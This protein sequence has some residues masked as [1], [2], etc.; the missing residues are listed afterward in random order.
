MQNQNIGKLRN[1]TGALS[2][3][4]GVY[5]LILAMLV[6]AYET[7]AFFIIY[8]IIILVFA[9][10]YIITGIAMLR[11]G[12]GQFTSFFGMFGS[13]YWWGGGIPWYLWPMIILPP[14]IMIVTIVLFVRD[15]HSNIS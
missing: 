12:R 6:I 11:R 15:D 3:G 7:V 2:L 9:V 4:F 1:I 14:V 5:A 10:I 8:A 13:V